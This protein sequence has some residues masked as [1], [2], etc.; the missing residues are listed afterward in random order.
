MKFDRP[1]RRKVF[2]HGMTVLTG[3]AVLVI[4][5]PLASVVYQVVLLGSP[6]MNVAFFTQQIPQACGRGPGSVCHQGGVIVPIEGTLELIG[7]SS[8]FSVPIGVGAAI[9][10]VEYGRERRFARFI[11][12]TADVLSGVP[13]IIAGCFTWAL[14]LFYDPAIAFS[15]L[16]AALALSVLM[17]PIVT[18]TTEEALRT[19]PNS[20]REA[21]M[22]LGISKWKMSLRITFVAALPGVITGILL[23]IARSAGE[24]APLLI[25]GGFACIHPLQ[26]I[27]QETCALPLW[28]WFGANSPNPNFIALAWGCALLLLL[29]ILA[30]SVLSRFVLNRMARKMRGE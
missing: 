29:L 13:S 6:V 1:V 3:L 23:A 24:A 27:T 7:L 26:G 20:V 12:M 28:I 14:F 22:A 19:V 10:A 4:M 11:G 21:S 18:R 16:D 25:A 9:F 5:I 30:M 17:V 15:T 8:L 2:S